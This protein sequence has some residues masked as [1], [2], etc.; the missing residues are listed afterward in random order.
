MDTPALETEEEVKLVD[1]LADKSDEI[2]DIELDDDELEMSGDEDIETLRERL[3][4]RNKTLRVKDKTN[5]RILEENKAMERRIAELESKIEGSATSHTPENT[6]AQRQEQERLMQEWR[7]SVADDPAKALDFFQAQ[8]KQQQDSIVNYLA[9]MQSTFASEIAKLRGETNP[10]RQKYQAELDALSRDPEFEGVSDEIKLKFI[11]KMKSAV[12]RV[13]R[14][15]LGGGKRAATQPEE[16]KMTDE[17]RQ[18][19]GFYN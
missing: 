18:A 1:L 16:F 10:E 7:E 8:Q 17:I 6:E 5:H 13:P 4:K 12:E 19:M 14:G 9:D 15:T 11:K 3:K 2:D